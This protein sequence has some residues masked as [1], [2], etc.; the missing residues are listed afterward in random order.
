MLFVF[1][2]FYLVNS[3]YFGGFV[4][5]L[6]NKLF[7]LFLYFTITNMKNF[8]SIEEL[9]ATKKAQKMMDENLSS[10]NSEDYVYAV[11]EVKY[12]SYVNWKCVYD[13]EDLENAINDVEDNKYTIYHCMDC[14]YDSM[15]DLLEFNWN[16]FM[17]RYFDYDAYHRDCEY[18]VTEASNGVII[19]NY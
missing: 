1:Y 5:S 11:L 18:D 4:K 2:E 17:E 15:D 8:E 19:A 12:W 14:Y 13:Y 7:G 10:Y 9:L 3:L 16:D 6:K